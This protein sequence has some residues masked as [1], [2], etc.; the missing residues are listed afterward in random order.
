MKSESKPNP[1]G[2]NS[3]RN[4]LE[5][6]GA[7]AAASSVA[8]NAAP[9][10]P[11]Q[12][13][14]GGAAG[15]G[16]RREAPQVPGPLSKEPMPMVKFGKYDVSRLIIGSNIVGGL[17]HLSQMID[18]EIRAW[19][20]PEHLMDNF[21]HC[22]DLGINC[23]ESGERHIPRYNKERGGKMLFATRNQAPLDESIRPGRGAKE[24]AAGGCMAIHHGGAGETGTDAWWRKGKLDRVREWCKAVRDA[25]VLVAVTS[26]RPEVFDI[27][28]SQDWDVDYYMTCL[29]K[30]GR[31]PAEWEKSFAS[32]PGMAPAELYHSRE[33][34]SEHYGGET[35]FVRGDPAEMYRIIQQTRKPC[36]V[37]KLLASG[38]L[39][40]TAAF[41]EAAFK[42]CFSKIKS[43]DAVV[44]GMWDKHLDQYAID[45]EYVVKY[46]G[47]SIKPGGTSPSAA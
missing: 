40:E 44:V 19:N 47:L 16:P 7:L 13:A 30:Y 36:F 10:Q 22:E 20:T 34:T 28:E 18:V 6:L 32:N 43:T 14:A 37:Y 46:S 33:G 31:T 2:E 3:R 15:R 4:F 12:G 29:Y 42:E 8:A 39:C 21:K 27:I 1:T 17:S 25:G 35:A 26:H 11:P 23:M 45:K 24:I 5:K 9:Q 38:R 41:V